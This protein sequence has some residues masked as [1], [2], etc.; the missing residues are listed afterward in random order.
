MKQLLVLL[1]LT[2]AV[3][4]SCKKDDLVK[5][6]SYNITSSNGLEIVVD[7]N[8][9]VVIDNNKVTF[10]YTNQTWSFWTNNGEDNIIITDLNNKFVIV[11]EPEDKL[12]LPLTLY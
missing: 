2:V 5:T 6:I 3:F 8:T 10:Y 4:S 7:N 9:E 12:S 1:L 11:L